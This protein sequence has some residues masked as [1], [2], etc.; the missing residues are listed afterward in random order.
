MHI[1]IYYGHMVEGV[2]ILIILAVCYLYV[3]F[4]S[5]IKGVEILVASI[6]I[7]ISGLPK[8]ML[9]NWK[10][11]WLLDMQWLCSHC[12]IGIHVCDVLYPLFVHA[13]QLLQFLLV[14]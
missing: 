5:C 14:C 12:C 2:C 6:N 11:A 3:T 1:A 9:I 10:T 8:N 4:C 7:N 13:C